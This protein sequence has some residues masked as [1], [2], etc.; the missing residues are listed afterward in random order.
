M[1]TTAA[2]LHHLETISFEIHRAKDAVSA[3]KREDV[4]EVDRGEIRVRFERPPRTTSGRA[5]GFV[6]GFATPPHFTNAV[7]SV[8]PAWLPN[9]LVYRRGGPP[10]TMSVIVN[11]VRSGVADPK[12]TAIVG[13]PEESTFP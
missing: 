7:K 8:T 6:F 1:S 2:L 10:F 11:S 5:V 4:A 9:W 12:S 13:R 3:A